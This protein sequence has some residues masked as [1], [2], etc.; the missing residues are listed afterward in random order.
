[1]VVSRENV[2]MDSGTQSNAIRNGS[3]NTKHGSAFWM[4][5]SGMMILPS[6]R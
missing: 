2:L 5:K 4:H 6:F 3:R 1:M